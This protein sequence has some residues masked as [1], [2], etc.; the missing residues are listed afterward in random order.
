MKAKD[1]T[2]NTEFSQYYIDE[3]SKKMNKVYAMLPEQ[4][5]L[6]IVA[7]QKYTCLDSPDSF[8]ADKT[9]Y[10][11]V[12]AGTENEPFRMSKGLLIECLRSGLV[13]I[14]N[15]RIRKTDQLVLVTKD[16]NGKTVEI[17][18]K[19]VKKN[20]G[21]LSDT[22][23]DAESDKRLYDIHSPTMAKEIR[24]DYRRVLKELIAFNIPYTIKICGDTPEKLNKAYLKCKALG[25]NPKI[26]KKYKYFNVLAYTKKYGSESS[27]REFMN[28]TIAFRTVPFVFPID[29]SGMFF[30]DYLPYNNKF[31]SVW[32]YNIDTSNVKDFSRMFMN[33]SAKSINVC[34]FQTQNGEDFSE[35][36]HHVNV[37]YD[38]EINK[39]DFRSAKTFS[40]MFAFASMRRL[41]LD[42]L[43][44]PKIQDVSKMFMMAAINDFTCDKMLID[45]ATNYECMFNGFKCENLDLR[46]MQTHNAIN[47]ERMFEG[48]RVKSLNIQNFDTRKVMNF[49]RMFSSIRVPYLDASRLVVRRHSKKSHMF[50]LCF[51][52]EVELPDLTEAIKCQADLVDMLGDRGGTGE[53]QCKTILN[54]GILNDAMKN[55]LGNGS[56]YKLTALRVIHP[57]KFNIFEVMHNLFDGNLEKA[58]GIDIEIRPTTDADEY[59]NLLKKEN[60][61]RMM[62][63]KL[64]VPLLDSTYNSGLLK[65]FYLGKK[66][67]ITALCAKI[68]MPVSISGMFS[69]NEHTDSVIASN[70]KLGDITID[71]DFSQVCEATYLC[72]GLNAHSID[73]SYANFTSLA[74]FTSGFEQCKIAQVKLDGAS[75]PKLTN[76]SKMFMGANIRYLNL[77][78]LFSTEYTRNGLRCHAIFD[79]AFISRLAMPATADKDSELFNDTLFFKPHDS[80]DEQYGMCIIAADRGQRDALIKIL[81]S[82]GLCRSDQSMIIDVV[83]MQNTQFLSQNGIMEYP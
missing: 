67:I 33:C 47:M 50:K 29:S 23:T 57:M 38:I 30:E 12:E 20:R 28:V 6:R 71:A 42:E 45:S 52:N 78:S 54:A 77:Y 58:D 25:I 59:N 11:L 37:D 48:L 55:C 56:D 32:F 80:L 60:T 26:S 63:Y 73:L 34:S 69:V 82:I 49:S 81:N 66:I 21:Q 40:Q 76:V 31:E 53:S 1:D 43:Q 9:V 64:S 41:N 51:C 27:S 79:N 3:D 8:N 4:L 14:D 35:M 46:S 75:M 16:S 39:W 5:K 15:L 68:V 24:T 44:A 13:S 74:N 2:S 10:K 65:A 83:T 19:R 17:K 61:A 70:I 18:Q 62:G 72:K 7:L 36:F 22:A